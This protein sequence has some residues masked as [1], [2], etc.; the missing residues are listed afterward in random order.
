MKTKT[1][2]TI[3]IILFIVIVFG[4][5][6]GFVDAMNPK[7]PEVESWYKYKVQSEDTL[8]NIVP[9][10]NGYDMRILIKVVKDYNNM[11]SSNI[12]TGDVIELPV[13]KES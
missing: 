9:D 3:C 12:D 11:T 2:T 4:I 8:W 5:I 13:W 1:V 7:L 10:I 6:Y